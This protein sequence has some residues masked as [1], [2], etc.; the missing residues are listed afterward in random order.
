LEVRADGLALSWSEPDSNGVASPVTCV[1]RPC[2]AAE[3]ETLLAEMISEFS[4]SGMRCNL[5]LPFDQY[6][7]FPIEKPKVEPS[8]LP[9]ASRWKIKD[10]LDFDLEDAVTDVYAFPDDALRGRPE[11][12]NVVVSRKAIIQGNVDLVNGSDLELESI[13][14]A[15][16]ALRNIAQRLSGD[17]AQPVALLYL[18]NG[19]GIMVL[20]K[21]DTLYLARH[22]DFSVQALNEPAQQDSVMQHLALEIQ[23]SF[24]YFESQLGQ[25]PPRELV[26]FGPDPSI[27]LAN[28]LGGNI[29]ARVQALDLSQFFA[30]A[31]AVSLDHIN[32][33]VALGGAMREVDV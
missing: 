17:D 8:E 25:V 5:I 32:G 11:Q 6:Q 23:R 20:V 7:T 26:L 3:R 14:I 21:G 28:M 12:L 30:D 19:A 1:F 22:F 29:A 2:N 31:V 10:L 27:P 13:D 9:E 16:L 18:R 15:D 33:F 24:D 4:L